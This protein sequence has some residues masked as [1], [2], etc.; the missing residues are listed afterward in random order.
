V[1]DPAT[2]R[3]VLMQWPNLPLWSWLVASAA[4]AVMRAAWL[5]WVATAGL[6][7]WAALEVWKGASPFRRLLGAAVLVVTTLRLVH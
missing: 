5:A 6:V 7:V 4:H 1:T 3:I 2:G